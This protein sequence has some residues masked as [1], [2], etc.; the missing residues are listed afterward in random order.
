[1]DEEVLEELLAAITPL[2]QKQDTVMREPITPRNRL[3]ATMRFLATGNIFVDLSYSTRIAYNILSR[4]IIETLKAIVIVLEGEVLMCPS[5]SSEWEASAGQFHAQ[6]QFP[7][8]I[9]ALDGK[10]VN[11]RPP[12]AD[13]SFYRNYKNTDS[14]ILLALV[15]ANYQ[16]LFVDIGRNGRMHDSSVFQKSVFSQHL[17]PGALNLPMPHPLPG[18]NVSLSYV[19]VADDAFPLKSNIMKPY[20]GRNVTYDN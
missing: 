4:L 16:F 3:A 12:R 14:I 19:I 15:N 20:P 13:G 18:G 2:I 7:H 6:W 9:G 17:S 5:T 11:F 10:H 1:M 8:C